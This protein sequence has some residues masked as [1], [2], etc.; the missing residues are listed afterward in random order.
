MRI[1]S[2]VTDKYIYFVAVDATDLKTRETGLNTWTVYRS[3]NGGAAAA[4]TTPTINETDD[5]NMPGVYELLLDE[6]MTL[7]AGDDS[8]EMVFHITHSGMAPV[9]RTIELYRPKITAGETLT[10]SSGVGSADAVAI[11]GD[12]SAADNLEA[13]LDG[14]GGVTVNLT[15]LVIN[16][17]SGIALNCIGS[18]WGANFEGSSGGGAVF[19]GGSSSGKGIW[20]L[21]GDF[22]GEAMLLEGQAGEGLYIDGGPGYDA[23]LA[24]TTG[25]GSGLSLEG[26]ATGAGLMA[27]GGVAGGYF[28]GVTNGHGIQ[29]IGAGSGNDVNG[30]IQGNLSGSV[31][32]VTTEVT[33]DVTKIG[34]DAQSATD[35][36]DF[37]DS[38]YD[39]AT[40]K[41]QGVVLT[42]TVTTYTGNTPQTGDSFARLGAPAGASVSADVAAIK[43]DTADILVDTAVIGAAG[44]GLT[45]IPWNA[46]WDVEVESEVTDALNVYDPPTNT[47]MEARTLISASY[48]TSSALATVDG[49]VDDILV[50]TGTTLPATLSGMSG[51]TFDTAT[52]SL[53]ALRNRGDSAWIT[54]TGFSTLDAA[55]VNAEVVDALSTDTYAEPGQGAP[56]TTISLAAKINYLYK[57]WRNKSTQTSTTYS[58]YDDAGSTVDQ[59]ATTSDNGTTFTR[60][61]I[62]SGP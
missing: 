59:K 45:A 51:A 54:A 4:F 9:T 26:G 8:Q 21:G 19:Y 50:D 38:G 58:L 22:A 3:R 62:A 40:N 37:V 28:Y 33:A 25:A 18:S 12:M 20:A 60:E 11:S 31:N 55:A 24:T 7:D 32:S 41:V 43:S 46:A 34:G 27:F 5:T 16:N 29:A 44:A 14:T 35:L 53:E 10:V 1:P 39:P 61:E 2:G 56:G 23:L 49:I 15:S 47:E 13:M 52:D 36:K 57:A 42:D 48:A 30:D 17:P 6:D